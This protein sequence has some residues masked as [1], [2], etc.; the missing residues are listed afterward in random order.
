MGVNWPKFKIS[1]LVPKSYKNSSFSEI[2][3][4]VIEQRIS[5]IGGKGIKIL[6]FENLFV[7]VTK[8]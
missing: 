3:A 4:K 5:K 7:R 8:L 1:K 6:A 2:V